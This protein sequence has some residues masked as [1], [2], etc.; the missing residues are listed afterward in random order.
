MAKTPRKKRES[1]STTPGE[2]KLAGGIIQQAVRDI[3]LNNQNFVDFYDKGTWGEIRAA[4]HAQWWILD[5]EAVDFGSYVWYCKY[6]K[7]DPEP[8]RK[9]VRVGDWEKLQTIARIP[10]H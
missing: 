7:I 9:A 6:M 8:L 4:Q 5:E 1:S 3:A 2:V 10:L